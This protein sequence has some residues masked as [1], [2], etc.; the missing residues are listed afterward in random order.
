MKQELDRSK[1]SF[2]LDVIET[3]NADPMLTP[4]DFKLLAAYVAVMDW[5]SHKTWLAESLAIA[6]T[7]LSHGQFWK[8]R[9]RLLGKNEERRAYLIAVRSNGKVAA[10]KLVNP[11]RDEAREHIEAMTA[12]HREAARQKKAAK[13]AAPSLQQMEGQSIKLS[14]HSVE[15]QTP[16]CPSRIWGPVPPENGAYYPS[17]IT[18][19]EKGVRGEGNPVSNVVPINSRRRIA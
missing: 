3:A 17:M 18:P 9:S 8:S 7:G 12:Y 1:A 19:N 16:P 10:Y 5:P 6:K 15:G 4:A 13:R 2:K 11:W 14:L